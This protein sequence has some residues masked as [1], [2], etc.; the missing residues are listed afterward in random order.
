MTF[1][2]GSLGEHARLHDDM[3]LALIV[4]MAIFGDF[5]EAEGESET[6]LIAQIFADATRALG[7]AVAHHQ[8]EEAAGGKVAGDPVDKLSFAKR[9]GRFLGEAEKHIALAAGRDRHLPLQILISKAAELAGIVENLPHHLAPRLRVTPELA[10]D[11]HQSAKG[12]I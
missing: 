5:D 2:H 10:L 9:A 3:L 12:V 8:Q 7:D 6:R 4:A 1:D 11:H